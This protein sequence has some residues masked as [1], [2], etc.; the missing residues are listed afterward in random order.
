MSWAEIGN[1]H[2]CDTVY[3][4]DRCIKPLWMSDT[5]TWGGMSAEVCLCRGVCVCGGG[6]DWHNLGERFF[7]S[8][9]HI[10]GPQL[11]YRRNTKKRKGLTKKD[12]AKSQTTTL[13]WSSCFVTFWFRWFFF[14]FLI[15]SYKK[16]TDYDLYNPNLNQKPLK[17][18][19]QYFVI[20]ALNIHWK[21][22]E[23]LTNDLLMDFGVSRKLKSWRKWHETK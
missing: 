3:P 22:R 12:K 11:R 19:T 15:P 2:N 13:P 10:T 17:I 6:S 21:K 8:S 9:Q 20:E 16:G 14:F 18:C 5:L 23:L 7:I 4:H 1:W